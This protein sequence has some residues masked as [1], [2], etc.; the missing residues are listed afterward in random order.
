MT[1]PDNIGLQTSPVKLIHLQDTR[2]N[3]KVKRELLAQLET[4]L[5]R[6]TIQNKLM[7]SQQNALKQQIQ[8]AKMGQD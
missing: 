2:Q 6:N 3:E 1:N 4:N 8:A 5:K 7:E